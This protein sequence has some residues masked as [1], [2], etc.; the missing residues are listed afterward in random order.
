MLF[1]ILWKRKTIIKKLEDFVE[2]NS[3]IEEE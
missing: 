1:T 3:K 2:N